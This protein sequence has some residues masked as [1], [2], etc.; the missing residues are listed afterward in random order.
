MV[1]DNANDLDLPYETLVARSMGELRFRTGSFDRMFQ[2]GQAAWQFDQ[3]SAT[4]TFTSPTG[5]V[6]SAPAQIAGS[7]NTV[8]STWLWSWANPSVEPNLAAHARIAQEYGK[9]RNAAE[10]TTPKL[11]T[12]ESKAWEL[13]AVTCKL[14]GYQGAY[15][16]PAGQTMVFITF[17]EV[18]M[19]MQK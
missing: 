8:D 12:T 1:D 10:L 2:L 7:F 5:V 9:R 19:K 13:A 16:G 18:R 3:D 4:I 17:G 6:A 11:T 14:G 15:R